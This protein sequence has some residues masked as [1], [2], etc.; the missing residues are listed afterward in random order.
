MWLYAGPHCL[1]T[2]C[3]VALPFDFGLGWQCA[4][5]FA[6]VLLC[7]RHLWVDHVQTRP[8]RFPICP[9]S[10][11]CIDSTLLKEVEAALLPSSSRHCDRVT[12]RNSCLSVTCEKKECWKP[13]C[14]LDGLGVR[15]WCAWHSFV[16]QGLTGI[17]LPVAQVVWSTDVNGVC[18]A[19]EAYIGC[20][21]LDCA[22][23]SSLNLLVRLSV[24]GFR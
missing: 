9:Q 16:V 12:F 18:H 20:C 23:L 15:W 10:G 7:E 1:R 19:G 22:F 2:R 5:R 8:F 17:M 21:S 13:L 6:W 3:R 24:R 11:R 14:A 4:Q